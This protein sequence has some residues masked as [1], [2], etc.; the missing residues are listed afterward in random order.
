M[1]RLR[2][3]QASG[4]VRP[5]EIPVEPVERQ[6]DLTS[7]LGLVAAD[8]NHRWSGAAPRAIRV[9]GI[10]PSPPFPGVHR[11]LAFLVADPARASEEVRER[12]GLR[13]V[14]IAD[15]P[16]P[17]PDDTVVLDAEEFARLHAALTT[18]TVRRGAF[19]AV[20]VRSRAAYCIHAPL[21]APLAGVLAAVPALAA[22][23][24]AISR[25]EVRRLLTGEVLDPTSTRVDR[26]VA[27]LSVVAAGRL[28]AAAG[29][30]LFP[31]PA[32]NRRVREVRA[33]TA[34]AAAPTAIRPEV[35]CTNCLACAAYCP[36]RLSPSF[37][38]HLVTKGSVDDAVRMRLGDCTG[39]GVCTAVCP[40]R[41]PLAGGIERALAGTR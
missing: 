11:L 29:G 24:R 36:A 5:L 26:S 30:S 28:L 14:T 6:A 4:P 7:W 10:H 35:P 18:G 15:E 16:V 20:H 39:C 34:D 27:L 33:S 21:G 37:L 8:R 23:M 19:L 1:K 38:Y 12:L 25:A 2:L 40:A 41:I 9:A 13:E 22:A 3:C 17:R 31:F 32:F